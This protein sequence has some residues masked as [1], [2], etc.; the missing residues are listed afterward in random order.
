MQ[1]TNNLSNK[2]Y[3][4]GDDTGDN[5]NKYYVSYMIYDDGIPYLKDCIE[6][7]VSKVK[8]II[9]NFDRFHF[10]EILNN[11]KA[12]GID[13]QNY[14]EYN[15][16]KV[17]NS[18][19]SV[20]EGVTSFFVEIFQ[21][22]VEKEYILPVIFVE[23]INNDN[24]K[25]CVRQNFLATFSG[26]KKCEILLPLLGVD[27]CIRYLKDNDF[28]GDLYYL[29]DWSGTTE[30]RS[31]RYPMMNHSSVDIHFCSSQ[32]EP[33]LQMADFLAYS[34]NRLKTRGQEDGFNQSISVIAKYYRE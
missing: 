22:F 34:Y 24:W 9:G 32:D 21:I 12:V 2:I 33:L 31:Y 27:K 15:G 11:F 25:D 1:K 4:V 30:K 19:E 16:C 14:Y 6:K 26:T 3:I 10:R 20:I 29:S 28:D 18:K 7:G 8:Q 17:N 13:K 5:T 23:E